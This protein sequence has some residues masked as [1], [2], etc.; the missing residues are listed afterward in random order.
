MSPIILRKSATVSASFFYFIS[1]T[2]FF[3]HSICMR[4]KYVAPLSER[5]CNSH[6]LLLKQRKIH[7]ELLMLLL[8]TA[9]SSSSSSAATTTI[10]INIQL[11]N[12]ERCS[13]ADPGKLYWRHTILSKLLPPALT[14]L[15]LLIIFLPNPRNNSIIQG[16]DNI[17]QWGF[18]ARSNW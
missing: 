11:C 18:H 10:T 8:Q 13:P 5:Q 16:D 2:Y 3:V 12:I 15:L 17:V 14:C 6:Y 4:V 7:W 9:K 1:F